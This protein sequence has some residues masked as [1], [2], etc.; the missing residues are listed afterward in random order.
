MRLIYWAVYKILLHVVYEYNSLILSL[1]H[2]LYKGYDSASVEL[3]AERN[4]PGQEIHIDEVKI[5]LF[6]IFVPFSLLFNLVQNT[7]TIYYG[8]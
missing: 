2:I 3:G 6:A 7:W 8:K 1:I 4:E 5:F